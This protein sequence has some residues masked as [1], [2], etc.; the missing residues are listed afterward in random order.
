MSIVMM[1]ATAAVVGSSQTPR[2]Q[3]QTVTAFHSNASNSRA[4]FSLTRAGDIFRRAGGSNTD[5]G[6]YVGSGLPDANIG[7]LYEVRVIQSSGDTLTTSA[8]LNV[9]LQINGTLIWEFNDTPGA[10]KDFGGTYEVR[11]IAD[12]SNTSGTATLSFNTEDGS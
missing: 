10:F 5:V 1:M 3:N 12:P 6:D 9:F 11:E 8:G 4:G 7:L 2:A